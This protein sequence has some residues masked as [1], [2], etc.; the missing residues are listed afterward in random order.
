MNAAVAEADAAIAETAQYNMICSSPIQ[1]I[2]IF[3]EM[4]TEDK[5]H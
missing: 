2:A 1:V 5:L 3:R 4:N